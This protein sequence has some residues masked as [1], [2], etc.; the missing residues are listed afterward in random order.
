MLAL[1]GPVSA[2]AAQ[3][4]ATFTGKVTLHAGTDTTGVFGLPHSS[5]SGLDYTARFVIA[6]QTPGGIYGSNGDPA[7]YFQYHGDGAF[8][9]PVTGSITINGVTQTVRR[10]APYI[11]G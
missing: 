7:H 9:A 11:S 3:Y 6:D 8:I 1:I 4:L 2:S 10:N 5:L